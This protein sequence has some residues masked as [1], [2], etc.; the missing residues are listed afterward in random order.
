MPAS[1]NLKITLHLDGAGI[2]HDPAEPLHL[3]A[4]LAVDLA[5]KQFGHRHLTRADVPDDVRLP[6]ERSRVN[7]HLV[8]HAS[9]LLPDGPTAETTRHWRARFRQDRAPGLTRGSPN[10]TN[11]VYRDWNMPVPLLLCHRMV[12]YA[13]GNRREV[14]RVLRRITHLGKKRAHGHGRVIRVEVD[15]IDEDRSLVHEGRAMRWLPHTGGTR[16]V[17]PCPP[18]WNPHGQV[19]CVE[20]GDFFSIGG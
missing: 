4:L 8:W 11:G 10:L 15:R 7:G 12:A 14:L 1:P 20:V 17:R 13:R 2:Y 19:D 16:R 6:L 3:D 5:T 9:A 18:Y